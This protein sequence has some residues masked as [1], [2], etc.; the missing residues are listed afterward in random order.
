MQKAQLVSALEAIVGRDAIYHHPDDLFLFEYDGSIDRAF[1][2]AVVFPS[3]TEQVS[4]VVALAYREGLPVV[5][6]GAGTG[7]SAGA[8]AS[9]GGIQIV[10]TRMRKI[11]EIDQANRIA[12]VEP[13]LANLALDN[14]VHKYGLR[15]A[16]DPSS[17]RAC[18]IGGNVAENAGGPHCLAF[19]VTTNHV[20][21]LEVVLEDGSVVWMGGKTQD[22]A[23][24][25]LRGAFVGSEGTFGIATKIVVRLLPLSESVKTLLAIFGDID[26]AS[27]AVSAIIARGI[28]PATLEMMDGL[29][30][31]AVQNALKLGFPPDTGAVLLIELE[32]VKEEVAEM[33]GEVDAILRETGA[34]DVRSAETQAERDRLWAGRKGALGALGS[35]A[36]NY[37]LVDTVVPRTRLPDAVRAV[38]RISEQF[39]TPI[40]N[41][42][43]AGDGNLHPCI[44]FNEREP[45]AAEKVVKIGG[46]IIKACVAI[47]GVPSGEHGIGMEK[48]EYL[49]LVFSPDDI[50]TM[51]KVKLAYSPKERMNPGKIFPDGGH[52]APALQREAIGRAGPGVTV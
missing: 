51:R 16:P 49:P 47:G 26:S 34:R 27:K 24:Y 7:L 18:S 48:K 4:K 43:H 22:Y 37:Y 35:L 11:L 23:G 39:N 14:E 2:A 5:A 38:G 32:G 42:F 13:G 8:I 29:M 40:A 45:G 33:A 1:P 31:K 25:D 3:T 10:L 9:K 28:V 20:L 52:A 50:E 21:G 6:R 15:F 12:V 19:G 36:P 41:V 44:L 30:V 46:E 17:Q